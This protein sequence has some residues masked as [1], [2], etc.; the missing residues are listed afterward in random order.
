M[1]ISRREA[2]LLSLGRADQVALERDRQS[3]IEG[4]LG[5]PTP[6]APEEAAAPALSAAPAPPRGLARFLPGF[7]RRRLTRQR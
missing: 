6:A 1:T 3:A 7:L 5:P 2:I 4:A